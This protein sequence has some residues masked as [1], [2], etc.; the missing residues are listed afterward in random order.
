MTNLYQRELDQ[1]AVNCGASYVIQ[2]ERGSFII[3]DG[4]YFTTGEEDR[5]Y[6]FLVERS[7]GTPVITAWFFSHAHQDHIG[8]FILF[9]NKYGACVHLQRL[10]YSFHP[11]DLSTADDDWKT[12]FNDLA[13]IKE[14][15][16]TIAKHCG[17]IEKTTLHTGD[18]LVFDELTIDV[19]YT[20]EELYPEPASFND[21]SAVII[22]KVRQHKILWLGD[23]SAKAAAVMLRNPEK[24]KCDIVQVAHH[25]IDNHS[26]LCDLYSATKASVALWPMPD[27]GMVER[28]EQLVND[29]LLHKTGIREHIASGYGTAML[30]L[31][32]SLGMARKERK[33]LSLERQPGE[34]I[35]TT[36]DKEACS[37]FRYLTPESVEPITNRD[38]AEQSVAQ[39]RGE[40][41]VNATFGHENNDSH[42]CHLCL[43]APRHGGLHH[44]SARRT[45]R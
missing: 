4:G 43:P 26:I 11:V 42:Q 12:K 40:P 38:L 3:I 7:E 36:S 15:E 24:L 28:R 10:I 41:R 18:E 29:F 35:R 37:P 21:Y 27:Y 17:E 14:F 16:R 23:A 45:S 20:Y 1:S 2:L 30:Q 6:R 22:T 9:M 39:R 5:L 13:T 33:S 32:Y 25:G 34:A 19:L 44:A 8:T 31:P